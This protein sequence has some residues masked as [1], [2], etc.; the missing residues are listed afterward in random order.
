MRGISEPRIGGQCHVERGKRGEHDIID[1]NEVV[2]G[3][4]DPGQQLR[5]PRV[6]ELKAERTPHIDLGC[7]ADL[8]G[9]PDEVGFDFIDQIGS[10]PPIDGLLRWSCAE[11]AKLFLPV[12]L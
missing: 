2:E 1:G 9:K 8:L 4:Y 10:A 11:P 6:D 3:P 7:V 5:M 12:P